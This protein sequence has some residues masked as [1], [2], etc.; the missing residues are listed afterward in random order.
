MP[1]SGQ[2][3]WETTL[4]ARDF[5]GDSVI[6]AYYDTALN[7]TWLADWN[8][9]GT[10]TWDAAV[11]WA[12]GLNVHGVTGWRLPSITD[13]GP[14]GCDI[15]SA[16]GTDCG[17]NVDTGSSEIAHMWYVTLGNLALCS[18]GDQSCVG[19]TQ[20]GWG[21]T[22]TADFLNMQA[23]GYWSGTVYAPDPSSAWGI[24]F[25]DG[26]QGYANKGNGNEVW[27]VAVLPG[28]VAAAPEP[29][30]LAILLAGLAALSVARRRR[31]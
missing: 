14:A 17:Y 9:T 31:H 16:V 22:N 3:T 28:D 24:S 11:A 20:P 2:G 30:T 21:L 12:A 15:S 25:G 26:Y 6:D 1:I 23:R 7:I 19:G 18:T 27:A 4:Q 5:N 29:R 13:T 10:M 8:A